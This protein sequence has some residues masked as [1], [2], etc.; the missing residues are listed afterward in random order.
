MVY[1]YFVKKKIRYIFSQLNAGNF[2]Y[3]LKQFLPTAEH[4]FSGH[5]ALSGSRK[6]EKS[7]SLWY[8]RLSKVFPGIKFEIC[9]LVV[10]GTPWNTQ[11]AVEWKDAV[12]DKQGEPLPN[13]GVFIIKLSWGKATSFQVYC[14]TS[15]IEKNLARLA[16][17]GVFEA[18]LPPIQD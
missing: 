14:D 13:H 7:R 12:F 15:Q 18:A 11:V 8:A 10:D 3:I 6:T 17:Q 5:H 9:K 16:N 2:D 1:H 4:S